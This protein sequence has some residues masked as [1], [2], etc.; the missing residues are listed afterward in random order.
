MAI[1]FT[2]TTCSKIVIFS[3]FPQTENLFTGYFIPVHV[4]DAC[5]LLWKTRVHTK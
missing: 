5:A 2:G 4:L 3:P 1:T